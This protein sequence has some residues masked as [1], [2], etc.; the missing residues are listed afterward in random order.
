MENG[1]K[2]AR[3]V[4]QTLCKALAEILI[5]VISAV[6]AEAIIRLTFS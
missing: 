3:K 4:I 2:K 5:T 6:I 1:D